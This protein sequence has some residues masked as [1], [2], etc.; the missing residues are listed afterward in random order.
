MNI[1]N[2]GKTIYCEI[3]ANLVASN[4]KEFIEQLKAV[5]DGDE[6]YKMLI[7][8]LSKT[9]S[10]DSMGITFLISS[11]KTLNSRQKTV[12]LAGVSEGMLRIFKMMKLDEV[13][14]LNEEA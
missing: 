11:Y 8:D 4:V 13:F 5:L 7:I 10:I 2:D 3:N 14:K 9:E 1:H 12:R 6:N